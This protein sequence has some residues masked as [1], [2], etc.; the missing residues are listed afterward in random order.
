MILSLPST[1]NMKSG[2]VL[3]ILVFLLG[4]SNAGIQP[5]F[6]NGAYRDLIVSISPDVPSA[7][8]DGII[9][10]IKVTNSSQ[11]NYCQKKTFV[12]HF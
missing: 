9:Q 10:G 4:N 8:K 2:S 7:D 11:F 12:V 1:E 3:P 5:Q 6:S